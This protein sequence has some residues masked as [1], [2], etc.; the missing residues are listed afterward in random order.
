MKDPIAAEAEAL[1]EATAADPGRTSALAALLYRDFRLFWIGLLV[2]NIGTWMQQFGL[3][4]L[5]VQ[6]AIRDATPQL[7]PLYLG[8][9]GLARAIP[10]LAFG[11]FGGVVADR[12]DRRRLLIVTQSSAAI[13]ATVLGV[14]TISGSINIVE[15]VLISA[16]NS[17]ICGGV[18]S[19][20]AY[21]G[22]FSGKCG[23]LHSTA[24]SISGSGSPTLTPPIA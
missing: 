1:D 12:A 24:A 10:G 23:S 15:V 11:L 3:G 22:L 7:A 14:L 9:V 8:L 21:R 13:L 19:P 18:P 16:I 17:I 5:V 4:W 20:I 2:S 6:L